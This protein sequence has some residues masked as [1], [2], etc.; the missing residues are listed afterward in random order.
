MMSVVL[1]FKKST[2]V[3]EDWLRGRVP[4]ASCLIVPGASSSSHKVPRLHVK[5]KGT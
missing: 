2:A 4:R 3:G 1:Q 5:A